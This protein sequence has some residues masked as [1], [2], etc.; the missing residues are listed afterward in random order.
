MESRYIIDNDILNIH[1][2]SL[3]LT[4]GRFQQ[5]DWWKCCHRESV[6]LDL[7]DI[8]ERLHGDSHH[9][10]VNTIVIN[11]KY[12]FISFTDVQRPSS[13]ASLKW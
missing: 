4:A 10:I 12:F 8:E 6:S 11:R 5:G 1:I 3:A 9:I 2:F 7:L 13:A